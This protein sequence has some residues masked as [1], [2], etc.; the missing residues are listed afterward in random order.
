MEKKINLIALKCTNCSAT[1]KLSDRLDRFICNYC[2]TEQLLVHDTSGYSFKRIEDKLDSLE[3]ATE[4]GNAELALKRLR[5]DLQI[6]MV[7]IASIEEE[8]AENLRKMEEEREKSIKTIVVTAFVQM[9]ILKQDMLFF[10]YIG[11][12]IAI[13]AILLYQLHYLGRLQ[14][15]KREIFNEYKPKF[16]LLA[17]EVQTLEIKIKN[18]IKI[19]DK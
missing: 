7:Q 17:D 3:K 16:E 11:F 15:Q 12:Q 6:K 19:V 9:V 2:G 4:K 14:K 10:A 8:K 18:K 1:L 13:L 5:E